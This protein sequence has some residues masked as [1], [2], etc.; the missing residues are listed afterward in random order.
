MRK[1]FAD[2]RTGIR[3]T[4][5]RR[6]APWTWIRLKCRS[7][8]A[9]STIPP[10]RMRSSRPPSRTAPHRRS[11]RRCRA[12]TARNSTGRTP[13]RRRSPSCPGRRP[14]GRRVGRW[15]SWP[16]GATRRRS[17]LKLDP[18]HRSFELFPE[19]PL[20]H[21]P[22]ARR[23]PRGGAKLGS[24][25]AITLLRSH[26][27]VRRLW[28]SPEYPHEYIDAVDASVTFRDAPGDRGT[29]IHV[30]LER[31][32]R[33]RLRGT[34]QKVVGSASLVKVND[35]LRRFKQRVETREVPASEG[36]PDG[37]RAERK[38]K[39]RSAQPLKESE[40]EK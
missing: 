35:D 12:S 9:A 21:P 36:T 26:E 23:N 6:S 30:E 32:P 33:G 8:S 20:G 13:C 19:T 4:T 10:P 16:P 40:L 22:W 38:L 28:N 17:G 24:K 1:L 29:E 39:Q 31:A 3:E 15:L 14:G 2:C 37:E 34:V 5:R 7:I 11:S 27:E 25:A 18:Y